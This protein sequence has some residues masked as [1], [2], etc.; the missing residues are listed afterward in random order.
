MNFLE[1]AKVAKDKN[2]PFKRSKWSDAEVLL[3]DSSFLKLHVNVHFGSGFI[4]W[5]A[6]DSHDVFADD[7]IICGTTDDITISEDK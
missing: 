4:E 1:A 7:W 3:W 2:K 5:R 6:I